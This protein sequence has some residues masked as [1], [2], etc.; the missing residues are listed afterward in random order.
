M[1]TRFALTMRKGFFGRI[2]NRELTKIRPRKRLFGLIFG[3]GH[4]SRM[5]Y[6]EPMKL[7]AALHPCNCAV[8]HISIDRTV[9]PNLHHL[10]PISIDK[11]SNSIFHGA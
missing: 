4:N 8:D 6:R 3:I 5:K 10:H 7:V 9:L 1:T 11:V 2:D